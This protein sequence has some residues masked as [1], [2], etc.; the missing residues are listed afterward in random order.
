MDQKEKIAYQVKSL[1]EFIFVLPDNNYLDLLQMVKEDEDNITFSDFYPK[2]K[3]KFDLLDIEIFKIWMAYNKTYFDPNFK[4]FFG[5][6]LESDLHDN[7]NIRMPSNDISYFM[8]NEREDFVSDIQERI[9]KF[10]E[11]MKIRVEFTKQDEN[12]H[13]TPFQLENISFKMVYLPTHSLMYLF[14]RIKLTTFV[15]FVTFNDY[16]K[17]SNSFVPPDKWKVSVN[18]SIIIYLYTK[19]KYDPVFNPKNYTEI[20]LLTD[21]DGNLGLYL[22]V[23][24]SKSVSKSRILERILEIFDNVRFEKIKEVQDTIDGLMYIPS[25]TMNNFV[26]L[27]LIMMDLEI[28]RY[29]VA[30]EKTKLLKK[31]N[32]IFINFIEKSK[33]LSVSLREKSWDPY[34]TETRDNPLFEKDKKFIRVKIRS[35]KNEEDVR[36]FSEI[37]NHVFMLYNERYSDILNIYKKFLPDFGRTNVT[38][39][40]DHDEDL[41]IKK[42]VPEVYPTIRGA[43]NTNRFPTII[44]DE[45]AK[46]Y[47]KNEILRFPRT[48]AEGIQRNY[49]CEDDKYPFPGL[50]KNGLENKDRFPYIPCC[51]Q[52]D[53]TTN[54]N[55]LDYYH[56]IEKVVDNNRPIETD[57]LVK[58]NQL[59]RLPR[60]LNIYF[61]SIQ[62]GFFRKGV[63]TSP[64]SFLECILTSLGMMPDKNKEEFVLTERGNLLN[65]NLSISKQECYDL[66]EDEIS[67][68]ISNELVY[69]SPKKYIRL[70]ESVY[71]CK[72]FLFTRNSDYPLGSM[73]VP[74]HKELYLTFQKKFDRC[75]LIYEHKGSEMDKNPFP[76][77]EYICKKDKSVF[78][79]DVGQILTD[80]FNKLNLTK[81]DGVDISIINFPL[82]IIGQKIDGYGKVR[83]VQISINGKTVFLNTSPIPPVDTKIILKREMYPIDEAISILKSIK[84]TNLKQVSNGDVYFIS[85]IV[86]NVEVQVE[87]R[88][89]EN[90]EM[91][92]IK[93]FQFSIL[94]DSILHKFVDNKKIVRCLI[95]YFN[96]LFA[97][98]IQENGFSDVSDDEIISFVKDEIVM[99]SNFKYEIPSVEIS[100]DNP[101]MIDG[102]MVIRSEE[103]LKK[104]IYV[105]RLAL[106]RDRSF[107]NQDLKEI[108]DYYLTIED[109]R[110]YPNQIIVHTN[111]KLDN[112]LS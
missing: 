62:T 7:L 65:Y 104:L 77:C 75:V 3:G 112:I 4:K 5:I 30:N 23:N 11:K 108:T 15:P 86:G 45:D 92:V 40:V 53:Q 68:E 12:I 89:S 37:L 96:Y 57:K 52:I 80:T 74:R 87:T 109:F 111:E 107:F 63:T 91:P 21:S 16:Y 8:S 71:N 17:I 55:Y 61:T 84:A 6:A 18:D 22:K 103:M 93:N 9:Q 27:D 46:A 90:K 50:K 78:D 41:P 34:D 73:I 76:Q 105:L 51:Y 58:F 39:K 31:N 97:R 98:Y 49:V 99:K 85:G 47:Q 43:C 13:I 24:V 66:S 101:F 88:S 20:Y 44:S 82:Q 106:E 38:V 94:E 83:G 10:D 81:V 25:Q 59:G 48:S 36:Y 72:I 19:E 70:L 110:R 67:N 32:S 54:D 69:L 33:Q 60:N 28:S 102:K 95:F 29:L 42:I 2:V 64:S 1:P 56:G 79:Q 26:F 100:L 35:A 14:D